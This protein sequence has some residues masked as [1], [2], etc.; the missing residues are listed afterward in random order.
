MDNVSK[1]A[2]QERLRLRKLLADHV[3]ATALE[4][5]V[6]NALGS[7]LARVK[8]ILALGLDIGGISKSVV[9][10]TLEKWDAGWVFV[11]QKGP[12]KGHGYL[13]SLNR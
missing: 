4:Q 1:W 8:A 3:P 9:P 10:V 11:A 5:E 12:M 6:E 13:V 2:D 7:R